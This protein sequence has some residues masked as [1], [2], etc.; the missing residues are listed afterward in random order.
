MC[1]TCNF[2]C[3]TSHNAHEPS[4]VNYLKFVLFSWLGCT[5][6]TL[7]R[8]HN[9]RGLPGIA[10]LSLSLRQS[11]LLTKSILGKYTL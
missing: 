10:R 6:L 8:M 9:A 7:A 1:S 3:T 5:Y 2:I 11:L 4:L